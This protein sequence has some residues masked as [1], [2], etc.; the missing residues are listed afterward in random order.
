VRMIIDM[1]C[2]KNLTIVFR[3]VR[4]Q[5]AINIRGQECWQNSR[6]PVAGLECVR[7]VAAV[8][9][10]FLTTFNPTLRERER[11]V[12]GSCSRGLAR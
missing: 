12:E 8:L 9:A 3:L 7:S 10:M 11:F 5:V 1:S 2:S 6:Q 4:Y